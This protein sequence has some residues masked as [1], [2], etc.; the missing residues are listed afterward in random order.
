[1][2][3]WVDVKGY[4]GLFKVSNHGRV[5]GIQRSKYIVP[6]VDNIGYYGA[7]LTVNKVT[8]RKRL[9]R[10][11]AEHFIP[12]PDNK[13]EVNHKDRDKSN[14]HIDN[15]EWVTHSENIQHSHGKRVQ[16]LDKH[17]ILIKEFVSIGEA[18]RENV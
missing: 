5:Y 1:M 4:E 6:N 16:M 13:P 10:L 8:V 2:E 11:V 14:N 18:A 17:G 12:N 9:H 7:R 3:Q 15:L